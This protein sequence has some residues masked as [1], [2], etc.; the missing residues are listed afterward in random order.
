MNIACANEPLF[1]P[2]ISVNR[3]KLVFTLIGWLFCIPALAL[4]I[5]TS[6]FSASDSFAS[7]SPSSGFDFD[8][9]TDVSADGTTSAA[10]ASLNLPEIGKAQGMA[11]ADLSSG[12]LRAYASLSEFYDDAASANAGSWGAATFGDSFTH[13]TG[14]APF[15]FRDGAT[16]TFRFSIDGFTDRSSPDFYSEAYLQIII[17][18]RGTLAEAV[19]DDGRLRCCLPEI[20]DNVIDWTVMGLTA[21]SVWSIDFLDP[22]VVFIPVDPFFGDTFEYSFSPG[23]DFDWVVELRVISGV[24]SLANPAP[25]NNHVVTDFYNTINVDYVAPAIVR[26]ASG[27]FPIAAVAVPEPGAAALLLVGLLGIAVRARGARRGGCC[28]RGRDLPC[29]SRPH[30][31]ASRLRVAGRAVA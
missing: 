29:G 12:T 11:E 7:A 6:Y 3:Q 23:R 26:S 27:A 15:L 9:D 8:R 16:S 1:E 17:L 20:A 24:N 5:G 28:A 25:A 22:D 18:E 30:D 14:D 4:P 10:A 31:E 13:L 21:E 2:R 19:N